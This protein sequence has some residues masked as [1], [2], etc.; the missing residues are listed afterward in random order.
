MVMLAATQLNCATIFNGTKDTITIRSNVKGTT[1]YVNEAEVG[2]DSAVALVSKKGDALIRASKVGCRDAVVP[3]P[4]EFDPVSLL[5][6]FLDL[7]LVSMLLIDGAATGA[8]TKA[9]Q[10]NFV[11]T[12]VCE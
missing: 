11:V 6:I 9:S 8:I 3:V 7:G 5:G 12:P 2:T 4:T 10:T 1:F